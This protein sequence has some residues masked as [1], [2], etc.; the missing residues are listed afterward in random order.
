MTEPVWLEYDALIA[1]HAATIMEHGGSPGL[2]DDSALARAQN[3][4]AYEGVEDIPRLAATYAFGIAKNHPFIDGNTRS[5]F[6]AAIVFIETNGLA[7]SATEADAADIFLGL[8]A[9]DVTEEALTDWL[10]ANSAAR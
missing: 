1:L 9:G 6:L 7:F 4:F 5:A 10:R 2:R 8:A 3:V